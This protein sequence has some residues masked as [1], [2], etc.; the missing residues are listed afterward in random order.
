MKKCPICDKTFNDDKK[1]CQTDGTL[2]VDAVEA[3]PPDD[4]YKTTVARPDEIAAAIP[5]S[6]PFKT[7]VGGGIDA[8]KN[9][10][11]GNLLQLPE[12]HDPLKTMVVSESELRREM[13][14][15]KPKEDVID[16]PPVADNVQGAKD[17]SIP[18]EPP[19]FNEPNLTPPT[20]GTG[21]SGQAESAKPPVSEK[22]APPSSPFDNNPFGGTEN[23]GDKTVQVSSD[24]PFASPPPDI[25]PFNSFGDETSNRPTGPIPSPFD[26]AKPTSFDPPLTPL[27]TYKEAESEPKS[28][29]SKNPFAPKP[30]E[31]PAKKDDPFAPTPFGQ[32]ANA[33]TGTP[34][35]QTGWTPPPAPEAG[36]QNKEIGKNT[37]LEPPVAAGQSQTLAIVSLVV[38]ILS[39]FCCWWFIPGIAAL[40][41]GFMAKSKADQNPNEYGG[42]GLA[43]GGIIT[44]GIS[45][46]LGIG[47]VILYFL[48][49]VGSIMAGSM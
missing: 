2:L 43:L 14:A 26:K 36:W 7:V 33:A 31:E 37:P 17:Y 27:P 1:F 48:G 15:G 47:I 12:E 9:Q 24:N 8:A 6:D 21:G 29:E 11:S 4:P 25:S 49:I 38:G 20:F 18:P 3:A 22:T 32:G 30:F 46:L 45:V 19:K 39:L 16:L 44:G 34:P 41:L 28:D 5:P 35:V 13:E 10:D 40:V 42:R 23:A